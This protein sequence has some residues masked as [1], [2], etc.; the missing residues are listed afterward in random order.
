M[1]ATNSA[2]V[3]LSNTA[4]SQSKKKFI[5]I[6]III[7]IA[8]MLGRMWWHGHYYEETENA[9]V[10]GHV[11]AIS[12]RIAGVATKVMVEDNQLVHEGDVLVTLDPADHEI[13][14]EQLKA[15]LAQVDAQINQTHAQVAQMHAETKSENALVARAQAKLK[16]TEADLTRYKLL[17]ESAI[18]ATSQAEF[19]AALAARDSA[20][21]EH[22]STQDQALAAQAKASASEALLAALAAQKK[23]VEAQVKDASLQ[24]QYNKII[25]PVSGRIGKK[26]VEVGVR[27]QAGQQ[28]LAIVQP[29]VWVLANFK[30]TQLENIFPGQEASVKID[31]FPSKEFKGKI[32]SISPASG[33]QF[34]L[35]PPD[36]AT[37]NFTKIVQRIPVKII[38]SSE[39]TKILSNRVAPGM[40]AIVE[41]NLRQGTP[42]KAEAH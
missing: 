20:A 41:V 31:A 26:N 6:A 33:A 25:A 27:V 39:D 24:L 23:A 17:Y 32:D 7:V 12:S 40:S 18:K 19:D 10:A 4:K 37:G 11:S 14:L 22:H 28:L 13:R 35:L 16:Q 34:S 3:Q 21:A 38:F 2:D 42:N 30:E 8:I 9:Y 36:N 15:Q 5:L 29:G 1:P